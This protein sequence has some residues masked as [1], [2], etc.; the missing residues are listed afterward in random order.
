MKRLF[1][2]LLAIITTLGC[3]C[4]S[5]PE[6][7][8]SEHTREE[9]VFDPMKEEVFIYDDQAPAEVSGKD[10]VSANRLR[11]F[12]RHY[13]DELAEGVFFSQS[14]SGYE[15]RFHGTK[16]TADMSHSAA[17]YGSNYFAISV[18]GEYNPQNFTMVTLSKDRQTLT[19]A[20]N[21][22]EGDHVVKLY[23]KDESICGKVFLHSVNTDGYVYKASTADRLKIEVFG[24]SITCGY[25]IDSLCEPSEKFNASTEDAC[26]TYAFL[27]AKMLNAD[28]S[29]LATSGWGMK[30]G[31]GPDSAIPEWFEKVD[32]MSNTEWNASVA[33]TDIAIV[34]LGAND[35]TYIKQAANS[36][37]REKRLSDYKQAYVAFVNKLLSTYPEVS[38]ICC[39]GFLNEVE[40]F[41]TIKEIVSDFNSNGK[42]VYGVKVSG[43]GNFIPLALDGH[44][45]KAA[46]KAAANKIVSF[47]EEN[48]IAKRVCDL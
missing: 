21:L 5:T 13:Y 26:D 24:D 27:T 41:D 45:S 33:N 20:D 44:P 40:L 46:N 30:R 36:I 31:L 15:V 22:Q 12:G 43:A 7:N 29:V 38:V 28:L 39:Y 32:V 18:D 48:G 2:L 4:T 25:G 8:S 1:F 23:K 9:E 42:S 19:I 11:W 34:S 37:E 17:T 14:A 3:A 35:C 6:S 10:L 47:I 16:L